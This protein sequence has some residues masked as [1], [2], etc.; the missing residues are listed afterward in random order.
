LWYRKAECLCG[1]HVDDQFEFRRP[2][3]RSKAFSFDHLIGTGDKRGWNFQAKCLRSFE[4]DNKFKFG[5]LLDRRS[6][7]FKGS[8]TPSVSTCL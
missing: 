8:L 2:L 3:H 6:A 4:I 7:G 1:L 5:R